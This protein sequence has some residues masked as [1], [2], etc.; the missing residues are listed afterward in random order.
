MLNQAQD[1]QVSLC[2]ALDRIL[3]K[4]AVVVADVTISVANIDLSKPTSSADLSTRANDSRARAALPAAD[5][6]LEQRLQRLE[7]QLTPLH[8]PSQG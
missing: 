3:N 2:E 6:D 7:A 4:G 8:E 5:L 1:Q